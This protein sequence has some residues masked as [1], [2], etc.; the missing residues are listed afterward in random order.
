MA[1][2]LFYEEFGTGIPVTLLHGYPLD[3]TIW[4]ELVPVLKEKARIILPD[5]RGHGRSPKPEGRYSMREMADDVVKLFDD[6]A[7][8]KSI[9]GGHSMG[10][11][12]ALAMARYYPER[13][14]GLVL[15]AS[16]I[17]ADSNE[18]R[19]SRLAAIEEIGKNGLD[20]VVNSMPEKLT[21]YPEV[22]EKCRKIMSN[23]SAIGAMGVTAA[24]AD[25]PDSSDVWQ[26]L[27]VPELLIAG[28]DD[29]IVPIEASREMAALMPVQRLLEVPSAGHL[30]MLEQ[31]ELV[32]KEL[33]AFINLF[34][35]G[36]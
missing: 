32:A 20:S 35:R 11:Y 4:M 33:I 6:L 19:K 22:V 34:E 7:I 27:S 10:G 21:N 13:V 26:G 31:P 36:D 9:V 3:H 8:E 12:V 14:S 28:K 16:Q 1:V 24:M 25:R 2:N 5:L 15:V 29:R 30:P 23:A 17:Y 18:K